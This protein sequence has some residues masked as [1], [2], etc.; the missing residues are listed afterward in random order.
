MGFIVI[1]FTRVSSTQEIA[2]RI[3][4][5][6]T[7]VVADTMTNGYGRMRR[8]W[9]APW[10]GLWMSVILRATEKTQLATIAAGVAVVEALQK[11]NINANL[12]WPNDV[13]YKGKKLCGILGETHDNFMIIGIGINLKNEIPEEIKSIATGI[14]WIDRGEL[15]PVILDE[16]ERQIGKS[17]QEIIGTWKKYDIT[18]GKR[19]RIIDGE[20]IYEGIAKD[21][22]YDGH[23]ILKTSNGEREIY[24]GDL[25]FIQ[26]GDCTH[27]I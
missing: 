2:K 6:N 20:E 10:G 24:T 18:L 12:K 21:I 4:R 19:V 27:E 11:F 23:L 5:E 14:P 22:G 17:P 15:L 3:M 8:K 7:V 1:H 16:F 9:F 26:T 13:I 25:I